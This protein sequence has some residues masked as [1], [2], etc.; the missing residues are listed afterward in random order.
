MYSHKKWSKKM[1]LNEK[2]EQIL[3]NSFAKDMQKPNY[4]IDKL[5]SELEDILRRDISDISAMVLESMLRKL[6]S[7]KPDNQNINKK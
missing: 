4:P 6:S 2:E 5:R 7:A 3:V 1:L